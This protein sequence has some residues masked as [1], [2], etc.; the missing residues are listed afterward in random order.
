MHCFPVLLGAR[1]HPRFPELY[2]R[3]VPTVRG[4]QHEPQLGYATCLY[5]QTF[6]ILKGGLYFYPSLTFIP[7]GHVR[8]PFSF[9]AK[10]KSKYRSMN[11]GKNKEGH[12]RRGNWTRQKC[13][14][15]DRPAATS[16][17]CNEV[18]GGSQFASEAGAACTLPRLSDRV[19]LLVLR[20][21]ARKTRCSFPIRSLRTI[22]VAWL[23]PPRMF[24]SLLSS[25]GNNN[26]TC[27]TVTES[28]V[29]FF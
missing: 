11:R 28:L 4:S 22:L 25:S 6:T 24:E 21:D 1:C 7:K 27:V 23:K 15:T 12:E 20:V 26:F 17:L 2:N 19:S 29:K 9:E 16:V 13:L 14:A 5:Y 18:S 3:S 8:I 10:K